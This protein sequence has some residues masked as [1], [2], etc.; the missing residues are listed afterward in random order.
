MLAII[1]VVRGV[2]TR[3]LK[4]NRGFTRAY[5]LRRRF[6]SLPCSVS[7]AQSFRGIWADQSGRFRGWD[8]KEKR[9]GADRPLV[10]NHFACALGWIHP[11]RGLMTIMALFGNI[12]T[13]FS[14]F[15]VNMLGV[16]LHSYGFMQRHFHGWSDS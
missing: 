4:T 11:A 2:F 6:V 8:P 14:W 1:Y 7:S 12:V 15:G 10:R 9:R 13:S 3:S 16:G 5:D